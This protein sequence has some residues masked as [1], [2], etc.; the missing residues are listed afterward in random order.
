MKEK[1]VITFKEKTNY[2]K[3]P[4]DSEWRLCKV[5]HMMGCS[6]CGQKIVWRCIDAKHDSYYK[7]GNSKKILCPDC[8]DELVGKYAEEE[9]R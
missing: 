2:R 1:I 5:R 9:E 3:P 7:K 4:R 8:Y 6:V